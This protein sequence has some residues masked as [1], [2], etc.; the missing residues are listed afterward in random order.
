VSVSVSPAC[1]LICD[2]SQMSVP[3]AVPKVYVVPEV[4]V[5]E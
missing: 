5:S 1:V 4:S 2:S 3:P